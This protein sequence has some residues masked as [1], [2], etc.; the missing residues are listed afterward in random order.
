MKRTARTQY[1]VIGVLFLAGLVTTCTPQARADD[2]AKRPELMSLLGKSLTSPPPGD[3][4][5]KLR[6]DLEKA[7]AELAKDPD[8]PE[9]IVWVGRRLGYLWRM[10]EAVDV[11]T[12]GIAK[13]PDYAPFYRHRGHRYIS[14][15]Q[16]DRAIADLEIA[17]EL[18]ADATDVVEQD[19]QPNRMNV[20]LT[21]LKYNIYY[22]LGLARYLAG[23]YR[24][25]VVAFREG[26][27]HVRV[28]DDNRVALSYWTYHALRGWGRHGLAKSEL[29]DNPAGMNIIENTAYHRL[30]M[31]YAGTIDS[32]ALIPEDASE[33][34]KATLR[35]GLGNWH[36]RNGDAKKARAAFEEVLSGPYW[37]AFGYIAAEVE[38]ARERAG[39]AETATPDGSK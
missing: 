5:A 24:L 15:R 26:R 27:Q 39:E 23:E 2:G 17:A 25:A 10:K 30:L 14:L 22:H 28:F 13:R 8:N 18:M 31:F 21:T 19:G 11:Y 9:K 33:L 32:E 37:P 12:E 16:F 35:Y 20:P 29:I 4:L 38:L 3:N 6:A 1:S 7:R 34:D 36:Q